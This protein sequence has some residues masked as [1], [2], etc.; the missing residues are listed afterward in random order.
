MSYECLTSVLFVLCVNDGLKQ[1]QLYQY[2]YI[3]IYTFMTLM[4]LQTWKYD[5]S[6]L[7][8]IDYLGEDDHEF[9]TRHRYRVRWSVPTRRKPIPR[10]TACVYFTFQVSK[11]K[12]K[13]SIRSKTILNHYYNVLKI[14]MMYSL[15]FN[16][17]LLNLSSLIWMC[18]SHTMYNVHTIRKRF[19]LELI[20]NATTCIVYL[21][22]YYTLF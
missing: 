8:C 2:V 5:N 1:R 16:L 6:W 17:V 11:I 14:I 3:Y 10:A 19:L 20:T 22:I 9:D 15:L 12:P 21:Y 4:L 7:Y 18:L 13:V